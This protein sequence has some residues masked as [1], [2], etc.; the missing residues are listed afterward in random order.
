MDSKQDIMEKRELEPQLKTKAT[1]KLFKVLAKI[2][3]P[4]DM[5]N[6]L[7]D[8]LTFEEIEEASRRLLAAELLSEGKTIREIAK[9]LGVSTTTVTR[10]NFWLHH[11][12]GG[13]RMA[14][15][16]LKT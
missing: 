13:Y 5:S 2:D 11:G 14:L 12:M 8:L 7:R 10:I 9:E 16:K 3:K 6:F 4:E 15:K 1:Q